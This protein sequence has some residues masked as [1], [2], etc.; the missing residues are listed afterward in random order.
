MKTINFLA[1][2]EKAVK[3]NMEV[4][5][6]IA[7]RGGYVSS[8]IKSKSWSVQVWMPKS[9]LN[10]GKFSEWIMNKKAEEAGE[11]MAE[12]MGGRLISANAIFF[13][14]DGIAF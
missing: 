1:E 6:S 11:W 8:M 9:Q 14:A 5:A 4:S 2:T 7:P 10:E 12:R 3:V 13:D